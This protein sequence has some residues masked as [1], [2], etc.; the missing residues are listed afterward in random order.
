MPTQNTVKKAKLIQEL[1]A[2]NYEPG[3]QDRCLSW[4][5]RNVIVKQYPMSQRTFFRYWRIKPPTET[6][7]DDKNQ[8]KLF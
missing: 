8:L 5:Y 1:V 2:R 6:P 7:A 3:R 4:V